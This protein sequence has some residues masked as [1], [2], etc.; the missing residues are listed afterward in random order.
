MDSE[1]RRAFVGL[2]PGCTDACATHVAREY[3]EKSFY[4]SP[5]HPLSLVDLPAA[6]T[7]VSRYNSR[8]CERLG[9]RHEIIDRADWAD[10]LHAL[11]S[12]AP[13]R[14]GRAMPLAYLERQEY[15][16]DILSGCQQHTAVIHGVIGEDGH[17]AAYAQVVQS[18]EVARVN[19][20]LGHDARMRDGVVWLLVRSFLDWHQARG[21][22]FGLY[23]THASGHGDGLRYFKERNG[24]YPATVEWA[25]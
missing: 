25:L 15:A 3:G 6:G 17:L 24:F 12:S 7:R 18:S 4:H 22:T 8:R 19:T 5:R 20:I 13:E 9:Y 1:T 14:Q 23:Y 10:D 2:E 21:A 16:H 11:R